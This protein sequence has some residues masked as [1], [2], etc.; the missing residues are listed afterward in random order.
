MRALVQYWHSEKI[1]EEIGTLIATFPE[2]NP[3]MRHLVFSEGSAEAFIAEHFTS[4]EVAAF[5]ACALPAMQSDYFRCCAVL[6]LGGVYADADLRC[7]RPLASMLEELETGWMVGWPQIPPALGSLGL[8]DRTVFGDTEPPGEFRWVENGFFAFSAPG[9]PLLERTLLAM[10]TSIEARTTE[11]LMATTGPG[12]FTSFYAMRELGSFNAYREYA[13]HGELGMV[14]SRICEIVG[15]FDEL[16]RM[17]DGV[18]IAPVKEAHKIVEHTMPA[19]KDT[20]IHWMRWR[21]SI[22]R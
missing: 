11:S 6:A 8:S 10:T 22:Y 2:L 7:L 18:A 21:R 13:S 12:V 15:S 17:L 3:E 20:D 16:K 14:A 1:P 9:H 19:Y 5:R 4:R